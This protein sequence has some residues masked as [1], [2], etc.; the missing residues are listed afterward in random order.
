MGVHKRVPGPS[1][2]RSVQTIAI[3][4]FIGILS[5]FPELIIFISTTMYYIKSASLSFP[6]TVLP[7]DKVLIAFTETF[8]V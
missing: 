1:V 4:G 5:R 8:L 6:Y 7:F 2:P 3:H